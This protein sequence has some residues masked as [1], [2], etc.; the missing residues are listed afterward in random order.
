MLEEEN[1]MRAPT[2]TVIQRVTPALF[3]AHGLTGLLNDVFGGQV[4]AAIGR[5]R[6][7]LAR[8][9]PP[10]PPVD[11][12]QGEAGMG[13]AE[14]ATA[15]MLGALGV[16]GRPADPLVATVTPPVFAWFGL[17]EMLAVVYGGDPMAAL[18]PHCTGWPWWR[19]ER[20]PA[21]WWQGSDGPTH[22][23]AALHRMLADRGWAGLE[24]FAVAR[25]VDMMVVRTHGLDGLL[26]TCYAGS[27]YQALRDLFPDLPPWAM[28]RVPRSLWTGPT[29]AAT[30]RA[31]LDWL[32]ARKGLRDASATELAERLTVTDFGEAGIQGCFIHAFGSSIY[33]A[34]L[35][36]RPEMQ[37]WEMTRVPTAFWQRDTDR[38]LARRATR[39]MLDQLGLPNPL[40]HR[41]AAQL[42]AGVFET[43]GLMGMLRRVYHSRPWEALADLDPT[44]QPWQ[45][46]HPPTALWQG[47]S[48]LDRA[49][50][51]TRWLV[52][53]LG[54]AG[55][56]R[57]PTDLVQ[58][59][60]FARY[61]L[62]YMLR[63]CY[64]GDPVAAL[65]AAGVTVT[66]PV[67]NSGPISL[68]RAQ[69]A[70][71]TAAQMTVA[72]EL[73]HVYQQLYPVLYKTNLDQAGAIAYG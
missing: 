5:V 12:W 70:A 61:G 19:Q 24:S 58:A 40:P 67:A 41:L 28:S 32:L 25:R 10:P 21:G 6:P 3:A 43:W 9:L 26:Q 36:V 46:R 23:R 17:G 20:V 62:G 63:C 60:D 44:L 30:A 47:T 31:A 54:L 16:P 14:G 49:R 4:P 66:E 15:Q 64:A 18:R 53:Q 68:L 42:T 73:D 13:R 39:W 72:A 11:F 8:M 55:Q 57:I 59:E 51:A 34:I 69:V 50:S 22:A 27:P 37:P 29:G 7:D 1:L 45:M 56:A 71:Q 2:L 33:R 48:G 38:A 65:T 52:A 35:A